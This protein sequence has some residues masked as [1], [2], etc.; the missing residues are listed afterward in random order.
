[1][2]TNVLTQN[3]KYSGFKF[4][5]AGAGVGNHDNYWCPNCKRIVPSPLKRFNISAI[6]SD[7]IEEVEIKLKDREMRTLLEKNVEEL[8]NEDKAFP[9]L[10]TSIQGKQYSHRLLISKDNI[11]RN[12]NVYVTTNICEGFGFDEDILKKNTSNDNKQSFNTQ[13]TS[14]MTTTF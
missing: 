13:D 3:G 11:N 5:E 4:M 7:D 2:I 10:I 12:N 14:T 6:I 8:E 1:M 9:K